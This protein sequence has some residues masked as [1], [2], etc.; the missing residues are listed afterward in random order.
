MSD[1]RFDADLRAVLDELAPAEVPSEQRLAVLDVA[2]GRPQPRR[3]AWWSR[4]DWRPIAV[5]LAAIAVV[6]VA[7]LAVTSCTRTPRAR[8]RG[9]SRRRTA[10]SSRAGSSRSTTPTA[11]AC[12]AR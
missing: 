1:E 4:S 6:L 2:R 10:R 11:T 9:P 12:C 3:R 7:A 8:P 5:S